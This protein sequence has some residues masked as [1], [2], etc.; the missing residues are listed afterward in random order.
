[1]ISI[2]SP[3]ELFTF[4]EF[5][6]MVTHQFD[7]LNTDFWQLNWYLFP[8][9]LQRML[10]IFLSDIERPT[11]I[12]GYANTEFT[13]EEFKRATLLYF[14][15]KRHLICWVLNFFF[16]LFSFVAFRHLIKE[17]RTSWRFAKLIYKI[18]QV[19]TSLR[20]S[21]ELNWLSMD[22]RDHVRGIHFD[23][24]KNLLSYWSFIQFYAH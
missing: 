20:S 11:I 21:S 23:S 4:C 12:R 6:E 3:C 19:W 8:S 7:L 24:E 2:L 17:F 9:K 1:M 5:G 22:S 18:F 13:R 15:K 10:I 16:S 14:N